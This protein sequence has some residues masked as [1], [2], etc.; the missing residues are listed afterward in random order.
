[1]IGAGAIR[2][3]EVRYKELLC[4]SDTRKILFF[5]ERALFVNMEVQNYECGLGLRPCF[6]ALRALAVHQKTPA[7]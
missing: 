3:I 5:L 2:Y 6:A 7:A 1:M 4:L